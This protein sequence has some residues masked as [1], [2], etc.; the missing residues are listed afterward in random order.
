MA[1][2]KLV[3]LTMLSPNNSGKRKYPITRITPH[4]TAVN[5]SAYRIGEIFK[6]KTRNASCN[7]G[8]GNDCRVVLV[9]PESVRSWCSSSQ[10]NDN[11]SI[12]IECASTN[13]HPYEFMPGVYNKLVDLC[14]DICRRYNKK[15]LIWISDKTTALKYKVKEDELLLTVHRWFAAK[16]CPGEWLMMRMKNLADEVT[17]KLNPGSDIKQYHTVVKG[18][19]LKIIAKNYGTTVDAIMLLNP[20]IKNPNKIQIGWEVRVR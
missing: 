6:P 7:Y 4:C 16:A 17:Q 1:E 15:R 10:D 8:I 3:D 5:V 9:C 11:R 20:F 14:V 2:S 19:K 13:V 18:D 12:T